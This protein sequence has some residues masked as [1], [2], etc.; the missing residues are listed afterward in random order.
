MMSVPFSNGFHNMSYEFTTFVIALANMPLVFVHMM[1]AAFLINR[2][3][4][5]DKMI[6][7]CERSCGVPRWPTTRSTTAK[8]QTRKP[9]TKIL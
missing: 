5:K 7:L 9:R 8:L 3:S 4:R 2:R 6:N 1:P